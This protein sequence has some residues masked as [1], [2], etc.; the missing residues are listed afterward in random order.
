MLSFSVVT[1]SASTANNANPNENSIDFG[2]TVQYTCVTG[3]E[4]ASGDL[5]R[6]CQANGSLTGTAPVCTGKSD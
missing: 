1:C 2:N 6:T 4:H 3:Y 5:T